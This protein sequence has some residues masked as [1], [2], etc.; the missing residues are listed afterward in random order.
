MPLPLDKA[1][2]LYVASNTLLDQVYQLEAL[3][4]IKQARLGGRMGERR[5]SHLRLGLEN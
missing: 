5:A 4:D 1:N 3:E 2:R